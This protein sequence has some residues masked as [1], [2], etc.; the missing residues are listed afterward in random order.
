MYI[1]SSLSSDHRLVRWHYYYWV[2]ARHHA[3][4]HSAAQKSKCAL[5]VFDAI[6][7][8]CIGGFIVLRVSV[9]D[10]CSPD[11]FWS[12]LG[13]QK[14]STFQI[15]ISTLAQSNTDNRQNHSGLFSGRIFAFCWH[16][17]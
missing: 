15:S 4:D 16:F 2:D 14:I 17:G 8:G 7:D 6:S 3:T 12:L 13:L 1:S 9:C 5:A 10:W 11:R